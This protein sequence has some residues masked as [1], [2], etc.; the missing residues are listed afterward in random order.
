MEQDD[1]QSSGDEAECGTEKSWQIS[2]DGVA[3]EILEL[4]SAWLNAGGGDPVAGLLLMSERL[5]TWRT[6]SSVGMT[7]GA[8]S[9]FPEPAGAEDEG[10]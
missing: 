4:A 1:R 8:L 6:V 9:V 10:E 3:P 5:L 7:R 2:A